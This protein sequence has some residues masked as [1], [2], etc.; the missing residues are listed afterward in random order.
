MDDAMIA[1]NTK[2]TFLGRTVLDSHARICTKWPRGSVSE[3]FHKSVSSDVPTLLISGEMDPITPPSLAEATM[4]NLTN[5]RHIIVPGAGHS[6]ENECVDRLIS[7][8]LQAE[9]IQELDTVC[10]SE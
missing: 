1:S 10:S 6:P 8:F 5:S 2:K 9:S 7:E 3:S 4:R